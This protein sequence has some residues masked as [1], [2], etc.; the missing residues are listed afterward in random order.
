[1][2]NKSSGKSKFDY[3]AFPEERDRLI[4]AAL[5]YATTYSK[6]IS[7]ADDLGQ[8]PN[9]TNIHTQYAVLAALRSL[10]DVCLDY[11]KKMNLS[12]IEIAQEC[13]NY[14]LNDAENTSD[15]IEYSDLGIT[16]FLKKS[17]N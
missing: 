7:E 8:L 5:L 16:D 12:P 4:R 11:A 6:S 17:V 9:H 3:N 13:T 10:Y 1:M 15:D 2:N 14:I